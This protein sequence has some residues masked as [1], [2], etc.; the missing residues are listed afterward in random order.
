MK[1]LFF[2]ILISMFLFASPASAKQVTISFAWDCNTDLD[3]TGSDVPS[4]A[5]FY[6]AEGQQYDYNNPIDPTCTIDGG[7]CYTDLVAQVCEFTYTFDT[8][9]GVQSTHY[10]VARAKDTDN[11]WGPWAVLQVTMPRNKATTYP[12]F[13]R[14][15]ERFPLLDRF[16]TLFVI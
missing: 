11:L 14:F 2:A 6:R 4:Y 16:L 8:L 10:W 13:L 5:L 12:L 15:L 3:G 1:K 9:D 7:L